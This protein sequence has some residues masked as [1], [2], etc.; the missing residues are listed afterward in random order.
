M[1]WKSFALAG[2][3]GPALVGCTIARNACRNFVNEPLTVCTQRAITH[4]LEKQA[5][6]AWAEVR[7]QYPRKA[8]TPEFR[9]GFTDGFVDYLDRGGH[10]S[11]PAAPPAKYV[12]HKKYFTPE[13]Q[14]R[15]KDYL[16]GFKYG[17]EIAIATGRR[18]FLTVPVLLPEKPVGPPAFDVVPPPVPVLP[19]DAVFP[20]G[21]VLPPDAVIPPAGVPLPL[22]PTPTLTP[23]QP[24]PGPGSDAPPTR[25]GPVEPPPGPPEPAA[26]DGTTA[27]S[28]AYPP[29]LRLPPPPDEVPELP[30]DIATPSPLDD[31]PVIPGNGT[32]VGLPP[33]LPPVRLEDLGK[34]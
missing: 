12:R 31:L 21:T 23:P 3:F 22:P 26:G 14:C 29:E 15:M 9:D 13:G 6:D 2:A 17:Q 20:P 34:S 16:L 18:Q 11:L 24:L 25:T 33:A 27:A 5:K 28:V 1:R 4:D 8:F 19:P 32:P 30:A 10:G 7:G